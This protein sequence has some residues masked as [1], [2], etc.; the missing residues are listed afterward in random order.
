MNKGLLAGI[1]TL[2]F[3]A[4][5][6]TATWAAD[7]QN[8]ASGMKSFESSWKAD[9]YVLAFFYSEM[10]DIVKEK[11]TDFETIAAGLK[12]KADAHFVDIKDP[13]QLDVVNRY[14]VDRAPMPL[15]LVAA[16]NG[17]I[18]GGFPQNFTE[19]KIKKSIVGP[20]TA[21]CLKAIQD[22]KFVFV[23]IQGDDAEANNSAMRGVLDFKN[24]LLYSLITEVVVFK[25]TGPSEQLMLNNLGVEEKPADPV[26]AFLVPPGAL[27]GKFT[28]ATD[29][30]TL[31]AALKSRQQGG[32]GCC[33]A[34]SGKTCN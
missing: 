11:R 27:I 4:V 32:G 10:N 13:K 7:E 3:G 9:R 21:Q 16:P 31:I 14:K 2:V 17:A 12:D 1:I 25:G 20:L 29:K 6:V 26:T 8:G 23:C 15:V 19:D 33:P 22:Q 18:T 28:G 24:E 34:G 30:D 5:V